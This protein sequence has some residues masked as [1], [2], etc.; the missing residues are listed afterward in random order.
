MP[1]TSDQLAWLKSLVPAAQTTARVW[2]VPASV[3][4][5]QAIVESSWGGS[6][7]SRRANNLFGIKAAPGEPSVRMP[8]REIKDGHSVLIE[9]DFARYGTVV[10]GFFAH[11]HLLAKNPR[12]APA[13]AQRGNVAAFAAEL[14]RCGYS[15]NPNYGAELM[16]LIR[17][18]EL[19]QYDAPADSA[20]K[21]SV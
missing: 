14:H 4:L 1:A 3:T 8:T 15:T 18:Y 16:Q 5:A 7:E 20:A 9:A 13:M 11:A 21:E 10:D 12:Y 17:E 19:T 6:Q 2:G